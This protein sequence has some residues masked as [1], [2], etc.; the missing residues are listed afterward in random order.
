MQW[1]DREDAGPGA[2]C[3]MCGVAIADADA[4][5]WC[6]AC[7]DALDERF[8]QEC[9]L[10]EGEHYTRDA[11]GRIDGWGNETMHAGWVWRMCEGREAPETL[12]PRVRALLES[13]GIA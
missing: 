9:G 8:I 5:L 11:A 6:P 4:W 7:N 2:P 3:V 1:P 12:I 13:D 10:L